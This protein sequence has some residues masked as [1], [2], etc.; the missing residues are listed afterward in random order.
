MPRNITGAGHVH[1]ELDLQH[2]HHRDRDRH[3]RR[4][5]ILGQGQLI[6]GTFPHQHEQ[7]LAQR[8]IHLVEHLARRGEGAG[9]GPAH[10]DGLAA[11]SGEEEGEGHASGSIAVIPRAEG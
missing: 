8:V 1:A 10:A 9:Q 2:A 6:L 5:G 7:R 4:L 11:L 3:Q